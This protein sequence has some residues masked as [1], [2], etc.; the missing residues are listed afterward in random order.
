MVQL[1]VNGIEYEMNVNFSKDE[2]NARTEID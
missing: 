2:L 1:Y